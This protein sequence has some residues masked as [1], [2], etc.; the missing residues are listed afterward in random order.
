MPIS[1]KPTLTLGF[2]PTYPPYGFLD[3]HGEYTGF[4]IELARE[5]CNRNGW[6]LVVEPIDWE[7]KDALLD[8]GLITCIWN[9]FSYEGREDKYTWSERYMKNGQVIC[10]K[11]DSPINSNDQLQDC[12]VSTQANSA[13][14]EVLK[15]RYPELLD[16][17]ANL[18]YLDNYN[19]AFMQ[20]ESGI[21]DAVACDLSA[22]EYQIS[23]QPGRF[24]ILSVLSTESYGV[25]FKLGNT[26]ICDKVSSA[27]REL[28][29][30]GFARQLCDKYADYGINYKNWLI[31]L[32]ANFG[33]CRNDRIAFDRLWGHACDIFYYACG[34][35]PAGCGFYDLSHEQ[36]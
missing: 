36:V 26:E 29:A 4:D 15:S 8:T 13:A 1:D 2:D 6:E 5:V 31:F 7:S 19:N 33:F 35:D 12:I 28:S 10:V 25:G 3:D 30:D 23:K 16:S 34:L 24:R 32:R 11:N 20:L 18:Q 27:L 14:E 9:G 17:F 22:A 21:V